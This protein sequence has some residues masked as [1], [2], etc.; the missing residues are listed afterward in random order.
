MLLVAAFV[1][2]AGCVT[3]SLNPVA[4]SKAVTS[5]IEDGASSLLGP[6]VA[7]DWSPTLAAPNETPPTDLTPVAPTPEALIGGSELRSLVSGNT[8]YF[9]YK[10]REGL[11]ETAAYFFR[12]DGGAL[13]AEHVQGRA[14]TIYP[15]SFWRS[16]TDVWSV[17]GDAVIFGDIAGSGDVL[18][19]VW[20]FYRDGDRLTRVL[21]RLG[22]S[23]IITAV[24]VAPGDAEGIER[25]R[26]QGRLTCISD[27]APTSE[28]CCVRPPG[29]TD[30]SYQ[31][32][33]AECPLRVA[34]WRS[35]PIN[36]REIF[37]S[38]IS[39]HAENATAC[40]NAGGT[41]DALGGTCWKRRN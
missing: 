14:K 32:H 5:A 25:A 16:S 15:Q 40:A 22:G 4:I 3:A 39:I 2:L 41:Y 7:P 31:L 1:A 8:L 27:A 35:K 10:N 18:P 21:Q 36:M 12:S 24:S 20:H 28:S 30:L 29:M 13:S 38:V 26:D 34:G 9:H 33:G 17:E 19:N 37:S 11:I 23:P 6:S